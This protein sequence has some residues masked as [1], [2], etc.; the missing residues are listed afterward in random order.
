MFTKKDKHTKTLTNKIYAHYY[1]SPAPNK[2]KQ[3]SPKPPSQKFIALVTLHWK[4]HSIS[5]LC[6]L[7]YY[8][9]YC[10]LNKIV[11]EKAEKFC[12]GR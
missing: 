5:L 2:M 11:L 10:Y 9:L 1:L 7:P 4:E 12:I 8:Y 3:T 6:T